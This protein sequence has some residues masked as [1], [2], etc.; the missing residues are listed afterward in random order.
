MPHVCA[1][2][3]AVVLHAACS[4]VLMAAQDPTVP[5]T[6]SH[7]LTLR[8]RQKVS[9][10]QTGLTVQFVRIKDDRCPKDVSCIWAGH[11]AVTLK[12]SRAGQPAET[13]VIGTAAPANMNLPFEA[14]AASHRFSLVALDPQNSQDAPVAAKSYR[15]RVRVSP[16]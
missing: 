13:I 12:I 5:A 7:E 16:L 8:Y 4:G 14:E 6:G 10:A 3:L 11:A 15:V 2:A 1:A 9:V